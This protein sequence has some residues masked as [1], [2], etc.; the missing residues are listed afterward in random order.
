MS[1]LLSEVQALASGVL[2]VEHPTRRAHGP[3]PSGLEA[4]PAG[5][6]DGA[7]PGGASSGA[8]LRQAPADT[9]PEANSRRAGRAGQAHPGLT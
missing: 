3:L 1:I 5:S 6:A 4:L 2:L 8:F 7:E 9:L